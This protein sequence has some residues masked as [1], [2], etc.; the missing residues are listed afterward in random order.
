M[1]KA[2]NPN[3]KLLY[4]A[5]TAVAHDF[6]LDRKTIRK[7]WERGALANYQDPHI[8]AFVSSPQKRTNSGHKQLYNRDE[9]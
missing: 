2:D 7:V 1:V 4:G 6:N 8:C 5:T 3:L 9:V